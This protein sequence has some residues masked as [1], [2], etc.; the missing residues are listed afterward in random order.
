M[1]NGKDSPTAV[2]NEILI[3]IK[4]GI[5][6]SLVGSKATGLAT[7]IQLGAP[8]PRGWVVIIPAYED[9]LRD[10]KG[11]MAQLRAELEWKL[12]KKTAFAVRSS[13]NVEDL[14]SVSF[15]GQFRSILNVTGTE[16]LLDAILKVW[17]SSQEDDVISYMDRSGKSEQKVLMAVVIQEMVRQEVSGVSFSLNPIT[18]ISRPVVE[19]VRGSGELLVQ[20]GTDT[21]RWEDGVVTGTEDGIPAELLAQVAKE[22]KQFRDQL[23]FDLDM[24]W[25]FDGSKVWWVQVRPVHEVQR[26]TMYS[27]RL[28]KEMLPG[29]IK[30]L[31]WSVN[32]PLVN[33]AWVRI[34]KEL[35][36]VRDMDPLTLAKPFHY[37]A[38][39][40]MSEAGKV[41]QQ[42]GLPRESLE[43]MMSGQKGLRFRINPKM[44]ALTPRMSFWALKKLNV[45]HEVN[46]FIEQA[47]PYYDMLVA[48]ELS[49]LSETELIAKVDSL[50]QYD[51]RAVYYNILSILFAMM[52]DRM[53]KRTLK[54]YEVPVDKVEWLSMNERSVNTYPHEGIER[55]RNLYD[56]LDQGA[57]DRLA[58]IGYTGLSDEPTATALRQEFDAH[59]QRFGHYSESGNDFSR[60]PWREQP[61]VVWRLIMIAEPQDR[62]RDKKKELSELHLS[63]MSR[64]YVE[65]IGRRAALFSDL[66]ERMSS[67]YTK[68]YGIFRR[69]FLSLGSRLSQRGLL[70]RPD[71]IF[72]LYL[73][74]LRKALKMD[75]CDDLKTL[76]VSRKLEMSRSE[77]VCL[78]ELIFGEE[79]PPFQSF[80]AL[81]L[82]GIASSGGYYRG[83]ARMVRG[84]ADFPSVQKGD[85]IVIPFS[86]VSWSSI[87][88]KAG[89]VLSESGGML[90]HSSIVARECGIPA[91]VSVKDAMSIPEGSIIVVDGYSGQVRV[92]KIS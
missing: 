17:G 65:G 35:T 85:V 12:P 19:A 78:P 37:R 43:M 31:V 49:G 67:T 2:G 42:M 72:Y 8:V 1:L 57:K 53:A 68:G 89:A 54:R 64:T 48:E 18:G 50:F 63:L 91:V 34:F 81:S 26:K 52:F 22:T 10:R 90:S 32:I 87:F 39:F 86:D 83:P 46:D 56:S 51:R 29:Q 40:N 79:E 36:G 76:I 23:K 70:E 6:R 25:V 82:R 55:M 9:Q 16:A 59:I 71:D 5:D 38:Y 15:A 30:P 44:L 62:S 4:P 14:S 73:E 75:A 69:Y 27:N 28:A 84:L 21:A 24:E 20:K 60:S 66:R 41:F 45:R 61:E 3:E 80:D 11:T 47:E 13:A 74:E 33:G 88:A 77:N 92:E 58:K 7:L